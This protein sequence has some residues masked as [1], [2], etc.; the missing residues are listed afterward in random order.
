M[1]K[2]WRKQINSKFDE[3]IVKVGGER[4]GYN[5]LLQDFKSSIAIF[6]T[7]FMNLNS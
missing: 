1:K 7:F 2:S 6:T 5:N 4:F 3:F